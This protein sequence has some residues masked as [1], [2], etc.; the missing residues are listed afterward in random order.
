MQR[1]VWKKF[2]HGSEVL[3]ASHH[4]DNWGS[5]YL[6]SISKQ[7]PDYMAQHPST[8]LKLIMCWQYSTYEF[9]WHSSTICSRRHSQ[10]DKETPVV[11]YSNLT[12]RNKTKHLTLV[13]PCSFQRLRQALRQIQHTGTPERS[14]LRLQ[15]VYDRKHS[16][17]HDL[18]QVQ[19]L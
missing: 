12:A 4:P 1:V 10:Q 19:T 7:L 8:H 17:S 6:W 9:K 18:T 13:S 16:I 3:T 15:P 11:D 14:R 5:K 2:I